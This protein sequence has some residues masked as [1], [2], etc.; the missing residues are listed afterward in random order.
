MAELEHESDAGREVNRWLREIEL[1]ASHE[2]EWRERAE[3]LVKRYRDE[4]RDADTERKRFN[5]LYSNTEVLKGIIYQKT[6]VRGVRR[7]FLDN[8]PIARQAAQ[9]L[10]RALSYSIDAYEFDAVIQHSLEDVLLTGR[11]VACVKYV[12]TVAMQE[13]EVDGKTAAEERKVYEEVAC[14]YKLWKWVRISPAPRWEKV[15]WIAFG[16]LMTRAELVKAF[17][18]RGARCGLDWKPDNN[19]D[20]DELFKRALVWVVWNKSSR[21]VIFVSRGYPDAPLNVVPDPLGLEVFFPCPPPLYSTPT[22]DTMIPVPEFTQYQDQAAELDEV[23]DRID[24]LISGLRRRGVYD[25]S[26]PELEKL[27][28]AGDNEFIP[29]ENF[30]SL[31]EKGGIA[32]ALWEEPIEIIAKVLEHLYR[33]RDQ[34]KQVIYEVTGIAD[35]VR[36]STAASET[37]GAQELKSKYANVRVAPRQKSIA[38]FARDILRLKAEIIAEKFDAQTLK[39]MT[40]ADMWLVTVDGAKVDATEQI[41]ALLR[42]EKMRGF[43]VDIETDSTVNPDAEQEQKNRVQLLTAIAQFVNGIAP[44]VASGAMPIE[45]A[46]ELLVFAVRSFKASP[47]LE[48]T[49]AGVAGEQARSRKKMM[50]DQRATDAGL[51]NQIKLAQADK[52]KAQTEKLRAE[53]DEI[54]M[55]PER[56]RMVEQM[57]IEHAE[58]LEGIKQ[59]IS[60][61][62]AFEGGGMKIG[63]PTAEVLGQLSESLTALADAIRQQIASQEAINRAIAQALSAPKRT[64]LVRDQLGRAQA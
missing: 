24:H 54:K 55:Q 60:G 57:K 35:I 16:E 31:S 46:Y 4:D 13:V 43:R 11:A 33:Q 53:A 63:N 1:A 41:M 25:N 20:G 18:D 61:G 27:Q 42:N 62:A 44:A 7:R 36:G 45:V 37:L 19:D 64:E 5:I 21:E 40:G 52:D 14:E 9:I 47:Q 17:G 50:D 29:V 58:I 22:N 30:T 39:M 12:P 8:D 15:R 26:Y 10:Q 28:R 49:L 3:K 32:A 56:E 6:P 2:R 59:A 23:T 34:L 48:D 51:E 38:Y